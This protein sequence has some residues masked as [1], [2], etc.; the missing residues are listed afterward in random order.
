MPANAKPD[1]DCVREKEEKKNTEHSR[2]ARACVMRPGGY[3]MRE[4]SGGEGNERG[5]GKGGGLCGFVCV[6][7]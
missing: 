4:E 1:G 5:G 7:V 2:H 6:C 3:L